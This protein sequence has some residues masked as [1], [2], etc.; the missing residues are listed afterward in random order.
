MRSTDSQATAAITRHGNVERGVRLALAAQVQ[1][2]SAGLDV[3]EVGDDHE[4]VGQARTDAFQLARDR[5]RRVLPVLGGRAAQ[6]THRH[7]ARYVRVGTVVVGELDEPVHDVGFGLGARSVIRVL[8]RTLAVGG[9][10]QRF[11]DGAGRDRFQLFAFPPGHLTIS[12]RKV[13]GCG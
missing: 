13:Y 8:P 6:K 1:R 4:P 12:T 3:V 2:G 7:K 5:Q 9:P 10:H 11:T